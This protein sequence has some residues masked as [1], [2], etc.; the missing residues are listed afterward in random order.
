MKQILF[1]TFFLSFYLKEA[2]FAQTI[3][4]EATYP[5]KNL[6][7]L[8]LPLSGDT[9]YYT[10]NILHKVFVFDGQHRPIKTIAYPTESHKKVS[11]APMNMPIS[12]TTFK[13][14]ALLELVWLYEDTLTHKKHYNVLNE[15]GDSIL[16]FTEGDYKLTVSELV[17]SP[18]KL[19]AEKNDGNG[20]YSTEVWSLP[21]GV[22][23]KTFQNASNF[24][25]QRFGYAGEVYYFKS[26]DKKLLEVY[27]P[28]FDTFRLVH[29]AVPTH[30]GSTSD[31]DPYFFADDKMFN[32]DSLIEVVF[33]Y[34]FNSYEQVRIAS[35]S[36]CVL[37]H[38]N[39]FSSFGIERKEGLFDKIFWNYAASIDANTRYRVL[40]LPFI[41]T[42]SDIPPIEKVY[43]YPVERIVLNH[44]G[45]KYVQKPYGNPFLYNAN[46]TFWKYITLNPSLNY[47]RTYESQPFISVGTVNSDT[48]I[49][50]IWLEKTNAPI[51]YQLRITNERGQNLATI[52]NAQSFEMSQIKGLSTKL[53]AKMGNGTELTETKV[54]R[55]TQTTPTQDPSVKDDLEIEVSPNPFNTS[56]SIHRKESYHPLSMRLFNA[57]GQLVFETKVVQTD[58]TITPPSTLIKGIYLL[59]ASDGEKRIIK[60]LV[61]W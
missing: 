13:E 1:F 52:P 21:N 27:K 45:A 43:D 51:Q 4:L 7:R 48:L 22:L 16:T 55:F 33:S 35:E 38:V 9:W 24:H 18:A 12:Q 32:S 31:Y 26:T 10:D 56:F 53:I 60:R 30:G 20:N 40:N 50:I 17:G 8:K 59:D 37:F 28:N 36:Q 11:L 46:H 57:L 2:I 19:I 44:F 23:E 25:R 5:A 14:D 6:Q 47:N 42:T 49:E 34:D 61:K 3:A 54:Y 41:C 39:F 58:A 15:Q 29:L